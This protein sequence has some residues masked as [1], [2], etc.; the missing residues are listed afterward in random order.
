MTVSSETIRQEYAGDG[1]TT[2]F[3]FPNFFLAA[4]D[5]LVTKTVDAT[6]VSTTQVIT[7]NYTVAGAGLAAGGSVTMLIAPASGE[8]LIIS[9]DPAVTQGLDLVENDPSPAESQ[10]EAY[11]RL[12]MIAQ[13][14][15]EQVTR[16]VKRDEGATGAFDTTL[17]I[18]AASEV[19]GF[20]AAK[21]ALVSTALTTT[22]STLATKAE[23]E[24]ASDNLTHMSPLRT[25]ESILVNARGRA[26]FYNL[27]LANVTV[28]DTDDSI[29]IVSADGTAL[30]STNPGYVV[31]ASATSGLLTKFTVVAPVTFTLEGITA[32]EAIDLTDYLFSV[33][34]INDAGS[35]KWGVTPI[36]GHTKIVTADDVTTAA[37][38]TSVEK[39]FVNSALS[40]DSAA[41]EFGW[42]KANHDV[43][44]GDSELQW[45]VQSGVGDIN[46]GPRPKI[47]QLFTP[48]GDWTTN[49]TYRGFWLRDGHIIYID[50][51]AECTGAPT[52]A[53]LTLDNPGGLL[54]SDA[55]VPG[56]AV[57]D[58]ISIG[59]WSAEAAAGVW[60][61]D[62]TYKSSTD[63]Y[64]AAGVV[65][66]AAI[67]S[68]YL[69]SGSGH[70][71]DQAIPF[72]FAN[73]NEVWGWY[74]RA[75][76]N[77]D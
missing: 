62:V 28:T 25:L 74:Q 61:G 60:H 56:T 24:E 27:A 53:D 6:G 73:G 46:L 1:T 57:S 8:T 70:R 13:N 22:V 55:F 77:W 64:F 38:L 10:E 40:G 39:V 17:P 31:M 20:N 49:V 41:L 67:P 65:N 32:G 45:T 23:A 16:S 66:E 15:K 51:V 58:S 75:I 35:L 19:I 68:T 59:R 48:T 29:R 33:Y 69:A 2:L 26:D 50:F 21:T 36:P 14:I 37:T 54:G 7:T 52:S 34:A 44:G 47:K 12:T 5:L 71:V 63:V 4:A 30:S 72:T 18:P 42:F 76:T 11:D 43:T 3:S 9:N